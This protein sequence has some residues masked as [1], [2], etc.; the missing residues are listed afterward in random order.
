M[1]TPAVLAAVLCAVLLLAGCG[2]SPGAAPPASDERR[3]GSGPTNTVGSQALIP[4]ERREIA[5]KVSFPECLAVGPTAF[6]FVGIRDLPTGAPV[7]VGL[8]DT[9]YRP[10][11][12][13]LLAPAGA[14]E[15]RPN[16]FV[17]VRGST[18]I[19]AEYTRL[20]AGEGC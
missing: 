17:T 9:G 11:R 19:I 14:L 6:R 1:R 4:Y 12:W 5:Q 13:R 2:S 16:L 7:P 18:G 20:P 3:N 10:D 15:D 8:Y